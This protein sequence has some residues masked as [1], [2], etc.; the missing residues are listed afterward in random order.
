MKHELEEIYNLIV[1]HLSQTG[2][3]VAL[4]K[5]ELNKDENKY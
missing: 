1:F 2:Y 3:E 4:H 5:I